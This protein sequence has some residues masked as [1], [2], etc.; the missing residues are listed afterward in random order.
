MMALLELKG[1]TKRFGDHTVVDGLDLSVE[2]GTIACLVGESG[3]GKTTTLS[4]VGG[5]LEPTAG[6]VV[7]GGTDVTSLPP[8]ERPVSTVFQ[9]YALF[10]HMSV[11][12]NVAYGLR[13]R[14][15]SRSERAS[16]AASML[17]R[18]GL[19]GT[20]DARPDELS[21]G[22][23]QRVAL[24][25]SLVLA[26]EVLL[27]DEPL[28]NLD[29]GLRLRM[30]E[31]LR[32]IQRSF[33]VTMVLVT[34]DQEEAMAMGDLVA[35]MEGGRILQAAPAEELWSRPA[36]GYV[37]RFLGGLNSLPWDGGTIHFRERD[38]ALDRDGPFRAR[39][40]DATFLGAERSYLLEVEGAEAPV[41][42][43]LDDSVILPVGE[44]IA[45]RVIRQVEW[46]GSRT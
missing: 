39:V 30:R 23:R 5:Y 6:S 20:A 1:L 9:D 35:V 34:H 25:R 46:K 44:H 37:A 41:R 7:V 12:Q 26:P 19:A 29:G 10:P 4:M 31:E 33:G 14:G 15:V 38:V 16:R 11:G 42:I 17:E 27:L 8:E 24:A 28:S 21:G 45:F 3:C 2:R 32:Q 43:R 18:V 22:Q 13:C 40:V 36:D